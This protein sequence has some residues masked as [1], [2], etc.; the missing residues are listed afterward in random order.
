[1]KPEMVITDLDGTFL[2]SSGEISPENRKTMFQ[3]GELGIVRVIA[4][5]R[6]LYSLRR[7]V[8]S[9]LPIDYIVFSSGAGIYDWQNKTILESNHLN[10]D[11]VEKSVKAFHR[12]KIDFFVHCPIPE[13]HK[14]DYYTYD[15][16]HSTDV[17]ER[18]ELYKQFANPID[19]LQKYEYEQ[20]CQV[21][22]ITQNNLKHLNAVKNDLEE[23]KVIRATSPINNQ[24]LSIEVFPGHISKAAA[25]QNLCSR[26]QIS[27]KNTL[28]IGN[29]YN[30]LDLL[31]WVNE[32]Y[33][34]K[35]A[36]PRLKQNFM[37]IHNN[38][39]NGFS[40]LISEKIKVS[41]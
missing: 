10:S 7:A 27:S 3:L 38:D 19:D 14:F 28:G 32:A 33:V 17:W 40:K 36:P 41:L 18:I 9:N 6:S 26:L 31:E 11:S 1:M 16:N 4:T 2:N 30:D 12:R 37:T 22:G 29:D 20:S 15:S 21:I 34:V 25:C 24:S 13:N 23:L 35:N 39:R 8:P 5:G